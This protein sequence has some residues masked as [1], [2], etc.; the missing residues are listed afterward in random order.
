MDVHKESIDLA[1]AEESCEVR[2]HGQIGGDMN[3]LW[4]AVRKLESSGRELVFVY[5]AGPCGFGIYRGLTARGHSCWVVAP[6]NTPRRVRDRIKTDRRDSLKLAGLAR[7]GELTPIYVPDVRDEAMRDL[8]RTREDAVMMQRQA[9]QRLAALLLRNDVR[10]AGKTAWTA[11]HRRWIADLRLPQSAQRLAFEEY[12]QAVEEA[13][14]R[15]QRLTQCIEQELVTWRWHS[16][17]AALQACRGIQLIHG[18]RIVAELGDLSRFSH[19]RRLMAYLGLIPSEDSSGEHRQQGAITKA[20][21]SS[22]RRALVEAAWA[23]QYSAKVSALIARRQAEVP[24]TA[25]DIAWKAQL[26]LCARFRRLAA[27][28]VNRNKIVVAIARELA[29]FVWAIAQHVKPIGWMQLDERRKEAA[30]Q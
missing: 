17:A 18:V 7:A 15:V 10:Y 1:V 4:R 30:H 14:A 21:N 26:R 13:S 16:V 2:H 20:G 22:A 12:V 25:L 24:K 23:Y 19:P 29:G 6:S 9:R 27:R 5:E 8:V 11:A 28:G 3:A